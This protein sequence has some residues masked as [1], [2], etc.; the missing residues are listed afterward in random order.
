MTGSR[1]AVLPAFLFLSSAGFAQQNDVNVS[2]G[3]TLSPAV[4]EP[5]LCEAVPTCH[6]MR[7]VT[8]GYTLAAPVDPSGRKYCVPRIGSLTR[9]SSSCKSVWRS[10]KS[11]S[12]V[13]TT[14]RSD[15]V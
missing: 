1:F 3:V 15:D 7:K 6:I 14:S 5:A 9:R 2:F 13:F 4:R 10:T 8:I 11:M 12:L